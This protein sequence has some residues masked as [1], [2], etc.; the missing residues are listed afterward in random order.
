MSTREALTV[1][2]NAGIRH[3]KLAIGPRPDADAAQAIEEFRE[4]GMVY[5]AHHAF[6]WGDRQLIDSDNKPDIF[7]TCCIL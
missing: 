5:R 6:V 2:W 4:L 3:T 1:F 7:N